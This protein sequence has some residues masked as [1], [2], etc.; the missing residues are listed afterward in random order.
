MTILALA[1]AHTACLASQQVLIL[2]LDKAIHNTVECPVSTVV[3]NRLAN[4]PLVII[5]D[6]DTSR[7][8]PSTVA[9]LLFSQVT[10][11]QDVMVAT[12]ARTMQ[13]VQAQSHHT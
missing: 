5:T 8:Q 3:R 6:M 4:P 2:G 11:A 12:L 10:P 13:A 7:F 9:H 1:M